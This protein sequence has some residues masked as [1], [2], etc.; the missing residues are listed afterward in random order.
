MHAGLHNADVKDGDQY[1]LPH[2]SKLSV[3]ELSKKAA[4]CSRR[5]LAIGGAFLDHRSIF[6]PVMRDQRSNVRKIDNFS[7]LY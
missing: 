3:V 5:V 7:T 6:V 2:V 4:N 1:D